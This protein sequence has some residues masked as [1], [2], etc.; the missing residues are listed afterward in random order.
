MFRAANVRSETNRAP[1]INFA[2]RNF[3]VSSA[4]VATVGVR[5]ASCRVGFV[6]EVGQA[7]DLTNLCSEGSPSDTLT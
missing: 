1:N 2:P 5:S 4:T 6:C 3:W 7:S